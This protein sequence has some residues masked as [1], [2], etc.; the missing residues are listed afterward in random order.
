MANKVL[1]ILQYPSAIG[2]EFLLVQVIDNG[3]GT[4]S[5]FFV[6]SAGGVP[7]TSGQITGTGAPLKAGSAAGGITGAGTIGA[8]PKFSA[9]AVIAD[10]ILAE[11]LGNIILASGQFL[12]PV[13]SAAL[14]ALS[15]TL[16]PNTGISFPGSDIIE[17]SVAGAAVWRITANAFIQKVSNSATFGTISTNT[18]P[19]SFITNGTTRWNILGTGNA[20]ELQPNTDNALDVGDATH[21]VR[22]AFI[23]RSCNLSTAG[24]KHT[25]KEGA[26]ASMGVAVLVGGTVTV[27]NTLITANSRIFLT[28]QNAS[29]TPG[30]IYISA[31]VVGTSFTIL[32]SDPADTRSIAWLIIEPN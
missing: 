4:R 31:R 3:D 10:S 17:I 26:N 6:D 15:A 11:T 29:G 27:N 14:P 19:I 18:N 7:A 5:L 23:G 2:A 8:I 21:Q 16:D 13:G 9:A 24:A 12:L 22:D 1:A 25:I 30:F 20:G 32:S 28:P